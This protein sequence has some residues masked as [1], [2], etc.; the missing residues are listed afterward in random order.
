C[1]TIIEPR[2]SIQWFV[3]TKTLARAAIN[4][5]KEGATKIIPLREEQRF[6][7]WMENIHDWCIS[8][9]LWWGHRIPVWYCEN[10]KAEI[11]PEPEIEQ[12]DVCPKCGDSKVY[13][14]PDVL[15]TWFSSALWS[16]STLGWPDVESS[17]YKR[18]FPTNMRETGYDILFFWVAREMMMGIELT[19]EVP[20]YNVYLHGLIRD[21]KGKKISKSMEN[22]DEYDPLI[23]IKD[24]GADSLRYVLISNSVPGLDTNF[25]L[26]NIDV[27]HKYCNK[28]WQASRY[29]LSNINLDD[30]IYPINEIDRTKL[31]FSD[32]WILSRLNSVIR[33]I[34]V[35]MD[36]YDYLQMTRVL[37][38]FFWG[39]FCDWYIEMSKLYLYDEEYPDKYIQKAILVHILET[40]Y[41][42]LHPVMPFLT[43]KLWQILPNTIKEIPTIMYASWPQADETFITLKLEQGFLLMVDFV[44]EIRRIK[45]DF[46][47]PLKTL[48]PLQIETKDKELLD[49]CKIELN[50]MAFIDQ[51]KFIIEDKIE[52]PPQSARLV[53]SGIPAFIPLS[54]M[55]DFEKERARIQSS[56]E[57]VKIEKSKLE[58][59]LQGQF[60]ERAPQELVE[61]ERERLN[62]LNIKVSH[63]EEQLEI[64]K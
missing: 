39:E 14:D 22:V 53:V 47:I 34:Q 13:Q 54:G 60:S 31:T 41:R 51:K 62:E 20:F 16:F 40:F 57:K 33:E 29:V 26:K 11:C 64:L 21:E 46:E 27:A 4:K 18:F 28:I 1:D 52:P 24:Y 44:R 23:I 59:K 63:F 3:K 48:V 15:D 32:K 8:R 50:K 19:D 12:L 7:L 45:H 2:L 37:K 61:R 43:E 17:D 56:L 25:D 9:Q 30:K 58:K 36:N 10:C 6:F 49:I 5:V 55:I 38:S 35:H 42:L